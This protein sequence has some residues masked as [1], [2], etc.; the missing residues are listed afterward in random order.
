MTA[1]WLQNYDPNRLAEKLEEAK[2]VDESGKI[3][4]NGFAHTEYV[5]VLNTM[6]KFSNELPELEKRKI[7]NKATFNAAACG[8]ITA[9]NLLKEINRLESDYLKL[10]AKKHVLV[11]SISASRSFKLKRININGGTISFN[12]Y[13]SK[14]F[15]KSVTDIQK[16]AIHDITGEFP[17]DYTHV[18]VNVSAKSHA[19]AANKALDSLDLIRG[20][21]NLFYNR[22]QTIRKSFGGPR[23]PVNKFVL[24]PLHTVH[25][26]NGKLATEYWWFEPEFRGPLQVYRPSD[27]IISKMYVYQD[28]VR[29]YLRKSNYRSDLEASILR[30]TRALD[31]NDWEDAFLRLWS[32]LEHLTNSGSDSYKVTV[33]RASFMFKDREYIHQVLS[34]LK[35]Y[36]NRAVHAGSE[37]H[38]IEIFM[39]QL[40]NYVEVLLEFHIVNRFGFKDLNEAGEFMDLPADVEKLKSKSK[41][42]RYA[43]KFLGNE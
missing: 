9:S 12:S 27:A 1:S 41:I 30:Y 35:D 13:L 37:N 20:I 24:G 39:Y 33:K 40:K 5:V 7:V 38:D 17:H 6:V 32:V 4:F 42:I 23:K 25:T 8:Q 36:R 18:K 3:S 19:E 43:K 29:S 11:T 10:P 21:W 26:P 15:A 34:H 28:K 16:N 14:T 22:N 2:I 31:L